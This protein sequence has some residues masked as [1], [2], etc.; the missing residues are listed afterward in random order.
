MVGPVTLGWTALRKL[1]PTA[2]LNSNL[3]A[4]AARLPARGFNTLPTATTTAQR[5]AAHRAPTPGGWNGR[6]A[7]LQGLDSAGLTIGLT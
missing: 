2:D 4:N 6:S 3:P 5:W 7:S 1:W